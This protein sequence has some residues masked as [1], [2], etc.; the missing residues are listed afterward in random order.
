MNR[1]NLITLGVKDISASLEFYRNIG[2]KA[3]IVGEEAHP[4]VVFFN[5]EGS[6]LALFP[7]EELANDINAGNPP[8]ISRGG[9]NGITLAYN[10][11]SEAEVDDVMSKVKQHGAT[12]VKHPQPLSWGGYGG[13]FTDIDGYYWEVAYG[14]EWEF[15]VSNMLVVD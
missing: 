12:V 7:I 5:N 1:I 10:G 11:K 4:M 13:Y 3:H 15:D 2:F 9:F 14:S 8:E 6:K